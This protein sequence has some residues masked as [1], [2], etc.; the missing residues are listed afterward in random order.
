MKKKPKYLVTL[1]VGFD[2][3]DNVNA[4]IKKVLE[5]NIYYHVT[6]ILKFCSRTMISVL[7]LCC[8]SLTISKYCFSIMMVGLLNGISLNGLNELYM[9]VLG[10]KQNGANRF[11]QFCS[12]EVY[13]W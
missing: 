5:Y 13:K 7:M 4:A 12:I 11:Y 2:Q 1:T 9:S 8:S 6:K 3:K 10:S